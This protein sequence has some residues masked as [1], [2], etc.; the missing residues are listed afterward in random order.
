MKLALV[1]FTLAVI[2]LSVLVLYFVN[3]F[4]NNNET[5]LLANNYTN[6][7]LGLQFE[8]PCKDYSCKQCLFVNNS[9]ECFCKATW[10]GKTCEHVYECKQLRCGRNSYCLKTKVRKITVYIQQ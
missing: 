4:K 7:S 8:N 10:S 1:L 2:F 9:L 5:F 6:Q 3:F